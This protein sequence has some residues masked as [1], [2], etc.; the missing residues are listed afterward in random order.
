MQWHREMSKII[1]TIRTGKDM[2]ADDM[3]VSTKINDR[4][5][6]AEVD[7][8]GITIYKLIDQHNAS[9]AIKKGTDVQTVYTRTELTLN[10]VRIVG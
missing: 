10:S 8:S 5:M 2:A 7:S 6:K 1:P 3:N 4:D 9:S